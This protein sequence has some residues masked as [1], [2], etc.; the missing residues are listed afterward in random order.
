MRARSLAIIAIALG[1]SVAVGIAVCAWNAHRSTPMGWLRSEFGLNDAQMH[2]AEAISADY[3]D[4]CREMCARIAV[5][6]RKLAEM[7]RSQREVT[8]E[9]RDAIASTDRLRTECRTRM[10][11]HFYEIARELP[12]EQQDRYLAIVLP[13]VLNPA[14][15]A[16]A[17]SH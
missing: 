10:L 3:Q 9:I 5:A 15:M 8:P 13:S 12:P 14:M 1:A 6:D 2:Q 11:E 4:H 16:E 7:I 17:H